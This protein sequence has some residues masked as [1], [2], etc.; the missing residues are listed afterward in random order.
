[1][2]ASS[3]ADRRSGGSWS[4]GVT[5][6]RAPSA[7]SACR[8]VSTHMYVEDACAVVNT[9]GE[10]ACAAL[11]PHLEAA[12]AISEDTLLPSLATLR[13]PPHC[14]TAD[15]CSAT[16]PSRDAIAIRAVRR[17]VT[18]QQAGNWEPISTTMFAP[19]WP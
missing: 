16:V 12:I 18:C 6:P 19:G 2:A 3:A 1:M 13:Q 7:V 4:G 5:W 17:S 9:G 14:R 8:H 11:C 15:L 10:E